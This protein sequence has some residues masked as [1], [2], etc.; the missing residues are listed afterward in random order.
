LALGSFAD[1]SWDRLAGITMLRDG[2][3]ICGRRLGLGVRRWCFGGRFLLSSQKL[4]VVDEAVLFRPFLSSPFLS[5]SRCFT[6]VN[7]ENY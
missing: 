4:I 7:D 2:R 6:T 1:I 5:I 3:V